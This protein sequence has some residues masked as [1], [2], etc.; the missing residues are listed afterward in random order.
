MR[1]WNRKVYGNIHQGVNDAEDEVLKM[2]STYDATPLETNKINLCSAQRILNAILE[3][4]EIFCKQKANVKWFLEGDRNTKY[5]HHT[6][7]QKRQ[8]LPLTE[9]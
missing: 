1:K 3:N 6:V 2:E 5:F 9:K 8:K 4:E 7:Q